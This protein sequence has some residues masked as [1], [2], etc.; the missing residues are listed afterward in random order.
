MRII[1]D[2]HIHSRHSRACSKSLEPESLY[3]WCQLKG[4][5][6]LAT[7]DF[8]HPGWF[9]A[10]KDKLVPAEPGLYALKPDLAREQDAEIAP[11]CRAPMRFLLEAEISC[12]YKKDDRV[13]KV[14]HLVF[15]PSLEAAQ[16][17]SSRLAEIGN[18]R[19]DGRPILGL[20]SRQLLAIVRDACADAHLVPAHAWTPH[21]AVFGSQSG[22]DSLEECFGDLAPEIFAVET[23]LS[24][25]PAMN[26]RLSAL[27]RIALISNSDAHSPEKLGREANIL[28]CEPSYDGI[29]SAIR[30]RDPRR[31]LKTIEFFPEEGKYHVDGHRKCET[32]LDPEETRRCQGLCPACGKPVT[33]GVLNRV[34]KLADRKIGKK[35]SG[36]ADFESLIPLKEV[37]GQVL[38]VGP[39]SVKLDA[40]YHRLLARFGSEFHILRELPPEPLAEEGLALLALALDRMRQGQVKINP[41][42]DGEYGE[43]T[44]LDDKDF[45]PKSQ[46]CLF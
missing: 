6:V 3:R 18:L 11:T 8:T 25:D 5:S 13:R 29:F 15:A 9:A 46:L 19:S 38:R 4:I 34:E 37:L 27:D 35:P 31:F 28:D 30:S 22:F 12:I 2:L 10:L 36:A 32:R 41:G 45:T 14:H 26:W 40:L 42:Y 33:V 20:D 39:A 44:L 43:I 23:G 24:S 1:A 7:G 17:I 21:F 16:R